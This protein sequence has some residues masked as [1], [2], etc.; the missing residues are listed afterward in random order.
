MPDGVVFECAAAAAILMGDD[1]PLLKIPESWA[2]RSSAVGEDGDSASHAGQY[3]T[4]MDVRQ[5]GLVEAIRA[6]VA[7]RD[8]A[9]AASYRRQRGLAPRSRMAVVVQRFMRADA[10]GVACGINPV[11]GA[12]ETVIEA[13]RGSG[14]A[15]VG[16]LV[17]PE[18][19]SV[20]RDVVREHRPGSA[21]VG[22][23]ESD[24]RRIARVADAVTRS[25]GR[26]MEIEFAMADG[27]LWLLQA[28][29]FTR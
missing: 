23:N 10:S 21:S 19:W 8:S 12:S 15:L 20:A 26:P 18:Y 3:D 16:G 7:S 6:V 25:A 29:P 24:V 1:V 13:V 4:V 14:A 11:T 5:D 17:T 28:R 22:W 27:T 2:V 9:K